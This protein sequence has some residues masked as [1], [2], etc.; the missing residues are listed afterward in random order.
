MFLVWFQL[1]FVV[2]VIGF[3]LWGWI[4]FVKYD[5]VIKCGVNC[6]VYVYGGISNWFG[7]CFICEVMDSMQCYWFML[8]VCEVDDSVVLIFGNQQ[9]G[10]I[11]DGQ[12]VQFG[13]VDYMI[14][15]FWLVGQVN[16]IDVV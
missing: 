1:L 7:L 11:L 6:F 9:L 4:D 16:V 2:G 12:C 8:F 10:F 3:G 13:G 14:V 5:M 15:M